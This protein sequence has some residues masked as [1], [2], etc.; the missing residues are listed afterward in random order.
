MSATTTP[1]E[2]YQAGSRSLHIT[3]QGDLGWV[4]WLNIDDVDFSGLLLG[5]GATR[6]DAVH[7][8]IRTL[9]TCVEVLERPP[10]EVMCSECHGHGVIGQL[11][12]R[13]S[14]WGFEHSYVQ[15][16]CTMCH[17]TGKRVCNGTGRLV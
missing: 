5:S 11:S 2:R 12:M 4:V 10:V 17:G 7:A 9:Q 14:E 1:Q 13:P 15:G 3:E 8:A 6:A 16:T